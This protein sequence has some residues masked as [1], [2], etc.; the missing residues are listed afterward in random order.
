MKDPAEYQLGSQ[1]QDVGM[2]P[3][4]DSLLADQSSQST[5]RVTTFDYKRTL[6]TAIP[7]QDDLPV[8][9]VFKATV[10]RGI[11]KTEQR[12]RPIFITTAE[13]ASISSDK[14]DMMFDLDSDIFMEP[15]DLAK[16]RKEWTER[17]TTLGEFL[18][19][20]YVSFRKCMPVILMV[21]I[22]CQ[23][24]KNANRTMDELRINTP[25]AAFWKKYSEAFLQDLAQQSKWEKLYKLSSDPLDSGY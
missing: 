25:P 1:V 6:M 3:R 15:S 12:L 16:H 20:R 4:I 21:K 18:R 9:E 23:V 13:L 11:I 2:E 5:Q 22:T 10:D 19:T 8:R 24:F 7:K 17:E 14:F